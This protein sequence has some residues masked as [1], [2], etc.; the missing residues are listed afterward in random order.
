M[1]DRKQPIDRFRLLV[2]LTRSTER[3]LEDLGAAVDGGLVILPAGTTFHVV[4]GLMAL[5]FWDTEEVVVFPERD[6][7]LG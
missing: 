4:Q 5:R 7:V 2:S 3:K 1:N 6:V